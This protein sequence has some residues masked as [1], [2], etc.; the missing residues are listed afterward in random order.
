LYDLVL[1]TVKIQEELERSWQT[2]A[3]EEER[4]IALRQRRRV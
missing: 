3:Q 4:E 2:L 1:K